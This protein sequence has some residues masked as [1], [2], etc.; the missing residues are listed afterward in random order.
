VE[1]SNVRPVSFG[2]VKSTISIGAIG[3]ERLGNPT[4]D[5]GLLGQNLS[6]VTPGQASAIGPWRLHDLR[7]TAATYMGELGV[8]P[9]HIEAVLNHYSGHRSGVAGVY[10]RAKYA[11]EMR[12]ALQR[13][14][15]YINKITA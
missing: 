13:W 15:D 5:T 2:T 3:L 14:A 12:V 10:Q 4:I 9:H 8:Q 7:R 6:F 11:D 1:L